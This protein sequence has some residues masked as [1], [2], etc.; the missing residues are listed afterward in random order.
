MCSELKPF[1]T[2]SR[3]IILMHPKEFKKEKVGTGRFTHLI[4][5]NSKVIVDVCFDENQEFLKLLNDPEYESYMLYPGEKTIN[6]SAAKVDLGPRKSQFI[7]IDGTWACAK[8]MV[9]LTTLLHHVQRVS[10]VT[11]RRSEFKIKHQPTPECLSTVESIHQVLLDLNRCGI[12]ATSGAEENL[13]DV[14]RK[15]V[16]QQ[17][18]IAL[19]PTNT[20]YRRKPYS[21]PEER[22]MSK[23]WE[24]RAVFFKPE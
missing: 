24:S 2:Q 4:L 16:Q 1:E 7:V 21:F 20:G 11:D 22:R 10:F 12:E 3:F 15:T 6:I 23:K 19:D 5:K 18:D 9:K 13:M 17:M 8:K 14:F